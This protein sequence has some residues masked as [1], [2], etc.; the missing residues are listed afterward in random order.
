LEL[1]YAQPNPYVLLSI[2]PKS[3]CTGVGLHKSKI[4]QKTAD[5]RWEEEFSIAPIIN[6]NAFLVITVMGQYKLGK[7]RLIGKV[8]TC[9]RMHVEIGE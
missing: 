1:G 9:E 8:G 6:R 7:D 4:L 3:A 5:P 2:S